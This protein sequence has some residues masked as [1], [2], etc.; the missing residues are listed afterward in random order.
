MYKI[1]KKKSK[2][3]KKETVR[4]LKKKNEYVGQF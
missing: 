1:Y 4:N 3:T 2:I